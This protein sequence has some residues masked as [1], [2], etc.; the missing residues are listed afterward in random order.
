MIKKI[1][2]SLMC[3]AVAVNAQQSTINHRISAV[4]DPIKHYIEAV[5]EITIPAKQAASSMY[6]LLV[7]DLKVTS[8]TPGVIISLD[9][10]QI[11]GKDFGMDVEDFSLSSSIV[12]NKYKV[13]FGK[14][15][16]GD[17]V[18]KIK[19]TGSINYQIKNTGEE[20]AR[21]FSQSP[22][23]ICKEG[24]YLGGSTYWV[25][26]FNE[27]LVSFEL[28]TD[29]PA[30]WD[31]VSQGERIR[32]E[33]N[34]GRRITTWKALMP[35]EEV[36][37]IAAEFHEYSQNA[38]AV[39]VM[40]FLRT[41][42]ENLANKYLETTA[43]YL[44]LYRKLIGVYPFSKFALIENFWE[45]GYG[46]ASFTLLGEQVIRFPFILHSSY[47]H[48]LL[49][50]YWGNS[51]YVDFDS[52]NWCEGITVYMADH[53][54]K[55]Q[56]G[57]GDDYRRSTI[58]KYT[59]YVNPENDF[60]L[61]KF[62]SRHNAAS[63]A[64]GYGKSMM[65]FNML[66]HDL[67]DVTFIKGFQKFYRD[68]KYKFASF[69][70]IR[71]AFEEVSGKNLKP[72]FKQWTTRT[73]APE[74]ALKNVKA[75]K[76]GKKYK[77]G[78]SLE[79]AQKEAAFTLNVPVAISFKDTILLKK[80][81]MSGKKEEY[82]FSFTK[83]PLFMQIDPQFQ[84]FRKLH[85]YEIPPALS[86]IFGS[87]DILIVLPGM[88]EESKLQ[89]YRLLAEKWAADKTRKIEIKLDKEISRLPAH[90]AVWIFGHENMFKK[91]IVQGISDY[92]AEIK[93]DFLRF[94]KSTLKK[95][96]HSF[97]VAVRH[98]EN[99][100]LAAAWLTIEK[101]QAINGLARK[102]LHYG[103]YSYLAFEGDEP[104][105]ILKGQ[106][107]AVH[108]PLARKVEYSDKTSAVKYPT[109]L[110]K[111]RALEYL[112]PVFSQD[113]LFNYVKF[114][115]ADDLKGRGLGTPGIENAAKYIA[116]QF[117]K[118]GLV[119]GAD[120][121]SYFQT[122]N[123][124]VD[125]SGNKGPVQNVIGIIPGINK[126]M[127]GESVV[128]SAHYDHLGLGWPDVRKGNTGKIHNGADDNASGVAVMMELA[129]LLGKSLRPQRTI[130]FIALTAEENGLVGSRYYVKNSVKYPA[131]RVIGNLNLDTVGRLNKN[132]LM[133][134]N[135]A[136]AREWKFIFMGAGYVCGVDA[137]M[138]AQDI[139][140]SDQVAFIEAGVPAVQFFTGAHADY[141]RPSDTIDKIDAA[142][143]VK[144]ASYVREGI[145]YLAERKEPLSFSGTLKT[146]HSTD[147]P[148]AGSRASTG[149]M[150]DFSF[151]GKGVKIG[152]VAESSAA[153]KAGLKK[154]DVI[155]KLGKYDIENLK[156]YSI[157]LK[158]YQPG[159]EVSVT[160]LRNDKKNEVKLILSER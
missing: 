27:N 73:G 122:W 8:E 20:Y 134:L 52:G 105:N 3:F 139:S 113:R 104:T 11:K 30:S 138:V 151:S 48:E 133:V 23:I 54:I 65:T 68:N 149:S 70:N 115:S 125:A 51:V 95:E 119:P 155:I 18:F 129:N 126:D 41:P 12:Q 40:A 34:N 118:A 44:E 46:M 2:F 158:A 91:V 150:P 1:V 108:S 57:Q 109:T 99:H 15:F 132:K 96:K 74:L 84:L 79:Q 93:D 35:M 152:A 110:P 127:A 87:N 55:E 26:W 56:R 31:A 59:D 140:A 137:E 72:F 32:H 101:P 38:G 106:W 9:K 100:N 98:P 10:S 77:L 78:F 71:E 89:N 17:R 157:A 154:G 97:V 145:L 28:T 61:N 76:T 62:L 160:Y 131:A 7:S 147:R 153:A 64:I 85:Y 21:G 148:K 90:K 146:T 49:H 33:I 112:A 66:R 29:L 121:G 42:D 120:N 88:A 117:K 45:T 103:K 47:P 143:M 159:D 142:G 114:L 128:I 75:S 60:P 53:L 94:G 63:E 123:E 136:S 81:S 58:Q 102:L 69:D 22:G 37:L 80:I 67:G 13:V 116:A 92:N 16:E 156:E 130:I 14:D 36:Y 25:P 6:F 19:M 135:T 4:V 124:V 24:V 39:E 141:H 111:R 82:S 107:K 5:D 50:N 86:R 43:Q 144:V 83:Q